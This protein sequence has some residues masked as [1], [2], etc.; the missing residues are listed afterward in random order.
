MKT[1]T[2]VKGYCSSEGILYRSR[3]RKAQKVYRRRR[4]AVAAL[5]CLITIIAITMV[6]SAAGDGSRTELAPVA[7]EYG[8]TLWDLAGVYYPNIPRRQAISLIKSNNGLSTSVIY[9]GDILM[10]PDIE[11]R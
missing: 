1:N 7:V 5:L 4:F 8:D 6:V 11:V 2:Y 3:R 10:L 9:E